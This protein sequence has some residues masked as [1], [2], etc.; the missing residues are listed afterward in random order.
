MIDIKKEEK[1]MRKIKLAVFGLG[2]G[3]SYYKSVLANN[4]EITA[5]CDKDRKKLENA[6]KELGES[7]KCFEKFDDFYADDS[8]EAVF[9]ANYYPQHA[10]FAIR[11][12]ERNIHVLSECA[13]NS[14]MAEGV[15]LVRAA[16]R[17]KAFYMLAENYPF[18]LF[19][20]E[21]KKKYRS[22]ILGK[23]LFGEGE[24]NHPI[25]GEDTKTIT[26][27]HPTARHWRNFLPRAY[28]IT[29]SL[30]PLMSMTGAKP[31]RVTA[32]PV[33]APDTGLELT[34]SHVLDRAAIVTILNE[35]GSVFRVTGCAA[36]GFEENSYR[37]C[38]EHGQIEN[39]RAEK[40]DVSLCFSSWEI[41][42]GMKRRQIYTP[43]YDNEADEELIRA[44][45]HG[46]GD[47]LVMREFLRCI[48][49]NRKPEF[50]VYFATS[51]ASVGILAH[52]SLLQKGVPFDIPDFSKEEDRKK[53]ENDELTP[54]WGPNDEPPSIPCCSEPDFP[55]DKEKYGI[56]LKNIGAK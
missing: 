22:G 42:E 19:N 47:F 2:R 35:D 52:R 30:A 33:F 14:T 32:M 27:L 8:Y 28:Y 25:S 29:H 37:L 4:A 18:M 45:G 15:R 46:G 5:V 40:G 1:E 34:G 55:L 20:L 16:E 38:C 26:E 12:L 13:S 21:M 10:D 53:W 3:A 36:F 39:I 23:V 48:D 7:V 51:M 43:K 9:L 31:K 6:K 54:F 24:Y 50:D 11:F 44:S 56:Y 41:P 17:S 49:E